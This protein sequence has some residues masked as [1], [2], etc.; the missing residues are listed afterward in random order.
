MVSVKEMGVVMVGLA[1]MRGR[2][3]GRRGGVIGG[4]GLGG[5]GLLLKVAQ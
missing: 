5:G 2:E 4:R 3:E 1:V